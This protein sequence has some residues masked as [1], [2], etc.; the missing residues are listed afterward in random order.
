MTHTE[1]RWLTPTHALCLRCAAEQV[2][3]RAV[4]PPSAA[5]VDVLIRTGLMARPRA[6]AGAGAG[7]GNG[8]GAGA[9][10]GAGA[11]SGG[12]TGSRAAVI[13]R[14]GY[15]FMLKD[16]SYQVCRAAV[17]CAF[18]CAS[19]VRHQRLLCGCVRRHQLWTFMQQ[20]IESS[21]AR[22]LDQVEVVQFLFKLR[23]VCRGWQLGRCAVCVFSPS[24]LV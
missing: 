6:S 9:G 14:R 20:Y 8:S 4:A 13:T 1:R 19:S 17:G 5:V 22:G 16:T 3:S 7:A 24:R 2:G 15:E 11:G 10:A 23:C 12:G 21:A 18:V